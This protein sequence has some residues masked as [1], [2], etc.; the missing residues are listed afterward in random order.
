[1]SKECSNHVDCNDEDISTID[2][3]SVEASTCL[4]F[5][6]ECSK[7]GTTIKVQV[8]PLWTP[9]DDFWK[10]SDEDGVIQLSGGPYEQASTKYILPEVCFT[11]GVYTVEY[12]G[13][14][15]L[16]MVIQANDEI[17]F[18]FTLKWN[19]RVKTFE[20]Y[21]DVS[22]PNTLSVLPSILPSISPTMNPFLNAQAFPS[23]S[24]S[25]IPSASPSLRYSGS[26]SLALCNLSKRKV[27]NKNADCYWDKVTKKCYNKHEF[28]SCGSVTSLWK[29]NKLK[30][31]YSNCV[32]S[33]KTCRELTCSDYNNNWNECN[34]EAN[35]NWD[36]ITK[37][38]LGKNEVPS[39]NKA[40]LKWK[41]NKL[42]KINSKCKWSRMNM[43]CETKA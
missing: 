23:Y 19:A 34:K 18:D 14:S 37:E 43:S 39:C 20:A 36:K 42:K 3:C 32:W 29:C 16:G 22:S 1:M 17:V 12:T 5:K 9:E 28:P 31:S 7:Y 25:L 41:C 4:Y 2:I 8:E 26:P 40:T 38:C 35:C 30:Q 6:Q 11:P 10:I 21:M 27:C 13:S 24:P 15:S 33:K